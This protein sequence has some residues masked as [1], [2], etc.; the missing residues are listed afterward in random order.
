MI[1]RSLKSVLIDLKFSSDSAWHWGTSGQRSS[2]S[3]T[4]LITAT[5]HAIGKLSN[6]GTYVCLAGRL[7]SRTSKRK[8]K[9]HGNFSKATCSTCLSKAVAN[10]DLLHAKRETQPFQQVDPNDP[11]PWLRTQQSWAYGSRHLS[12]F[13]HA[14]AKSCMDGLC[15]LTTLR[16]TTTEVRNIPVHGPFILRSWTAQPPP[17]SW[18]ECKSQKKYQRARRTTHSSP[19]HAPS[20]RPW[21]LQHQRRLA[22]TKGRAVGFLWKIS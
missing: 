6:R 7:S 13:L 11:K 10:P 21:H 5:I 9:Q 2:W 8:C 12:W 20:H 15:P 18:Y 19:Q 4:L 14:F 22:Q 17:S 3:A 1:I 16:T